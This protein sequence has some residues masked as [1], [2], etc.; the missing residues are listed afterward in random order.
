M[1]ADVPNAGRGGTA[2][3]AGRRLPHEAALCSSDGLPG[4]SRGPRGHLRPPGLRSN[5]TGGTFISDGTGQGVTTPSPAVCLRGGGR[6]D[7]Q[8]GSLAG[9]V[10][11]IRR[12][13]PT[14]T[15]VGGGLTWDGQGIER[16]P[17]VNRLV[18]GSSPPRRQK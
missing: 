8:A 7:H 12:A 16:A 1:P 5:V 4:P 11:V 13:T 3:S 14:L 10:F 2:P 15:V 9:S 18:V 17:A 6:G